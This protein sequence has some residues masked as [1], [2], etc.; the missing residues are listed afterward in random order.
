MPILSKC[1]GCGRGG[2]VPDAYAGKSITCKGCGTKF[3]VADAPKDDGVITQAIEDPGELAPVR[4]RA[5]TP[6]EVVVRLEG[7]NKPVSVGAGGIG[8]GV[9]A[10]IIGAVVALAGGVLVAG[11]FLCCGGMA[12]FGKVASDVADAHKKADE[13]VAAEA[14]KPAAFKMA[15]QQLLDEYLADKAAADAK[16]KDK[17][18][19]VTGTASQV[20]S[21][22]GSNSI[23][24][25]AD[26]GYDV[27]C[28]FD[29]GSEMFGVE[30]GQAV[31]IKG[32]CGGPL[33]KAVYLHN[34]KVVR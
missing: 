31:A 28:L 7:G 25:S 24:L 32:K 23:R 2:N 5:A 30:K 27:S 14:K 18:V 1:P 19:E 3:I 33:G 20:T 8:C 10:G 17:W 29:D 21:Q 11:F 26:K 4:Q 16:Y 34:C 6:P 13:Q 12:F 15:A 9:M 22:F